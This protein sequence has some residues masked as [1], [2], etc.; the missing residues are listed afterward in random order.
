MSND[1][2]F[3]YLEI[4]PVLTVEHKAEDFP[5]AFVLNSDINSSELGI[6]N[7]A[8]GLKKPKWVEIVNR[9]KFDLIVIDKLDSISIFEQEKFYELLNYNTIS[10]VEFDNPVKII[11]PYDNINNINANI[12]SVCRVI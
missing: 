12:K 11:A 4:S 1:K 3:K 8:D 9:Y 2:I 5:S 6:V 7:T 10:S